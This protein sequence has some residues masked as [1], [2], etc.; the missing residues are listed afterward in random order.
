MA[1]MN[2]TTAGHGTGGNP[3]D[4]IGKKVQGRA[5][6]MHEGIQ[7]AAYQKAEH[8]HDIHKMIVGHVLAKDYQTHL[9]K[10]AADSTEISMQHGDITTKITRKPRKSKGAQAVSPTEHVETPASTPQAAASESTPRE[11]HHSGNATFIG[12]TIPTHP[13]EWSGGYQDRNPKTGQA[14]TKPAY[15]EFKS[16]KQHFEAGLAS[17]QGHFAPKEGIKISNYARKAL[18]LNKPKGK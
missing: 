4:W 16:R 6:A 8:E 18:K 17:Q 7:K 9:S 5:N 10:H 11:A 2:R 14:Q 12:G 3:F 15:K 13:G 1:E